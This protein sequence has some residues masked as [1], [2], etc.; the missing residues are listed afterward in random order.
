MRFT[1]MTFLLLL[2]IVNVK[3]NGGDLEART[4]NRAAS[5]GSVVEV[6][7]RFLRFHSTAYQGG[8]I[9]VVIDVTSANPL[10]VT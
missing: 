6:E 4:A 8:N 9:C 2:Q 5:P 10:R 3:A 7:E 1:L